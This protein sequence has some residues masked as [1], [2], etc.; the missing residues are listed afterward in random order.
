[1]QH[2][3]R[4]RFTRLIREFLLIVT[5]VLTA[6]TLGNWNTARQDKRLEREYLASL[7]DDVRDHE[8]QYG[9]WVTTLGQHQ[10]WTDTIWSWATGVTPTQPPDQVMLW[11]KLGG[12]MALN[13]KFQDGA[14][15]DLLNSGRLGLISDRKLR[16]DLVEYHA[17]L[18]RRNQ[19]VEA[20]G[21]EAKEQYAAAVVN[22]IPADI[23]WRATTETKLTPAD[24][25]T[26]IAR[27]RAQPAVQQGLVAMQQSLA[28]RKCFAADGR[29]AAQAIQERI[30]NELKR[31]PRFAVT[32]F[33]K[34]TS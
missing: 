14:Y 20:N 19:I 2:S 10:A 32:G 16:Q 3:N 4:R 6:L 28:F 31:Q 27:F 8:R 13:T 21:N 15:Q 18:E 22:I 11:V 30:R 23:A 34:T 9:D 7:A 25:Q 17:R 12:Q 26:V 24:V 1:M 33:A 5:G 29:N